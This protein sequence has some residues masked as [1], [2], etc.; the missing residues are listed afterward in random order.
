M[1]YH[2]PCKIEKRPGVCPF[3]EALKAREQYHS[4]GPELP[5]PED[6]EQVEGVA[7]VYQLLS[8]KW[9]SQ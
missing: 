9:D 2:C 6:R 4:A 7:Q 8:I 5:S 3:L 1:G